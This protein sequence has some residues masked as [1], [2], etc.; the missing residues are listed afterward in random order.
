M[1]GWDVVAGVRVVSSALGAEGLKRGK[2]C[3]RQP[4]PFPST[5]RDDSWGCTLAR[6]EDILDVADAGASLEV[7]GPTM[8]GGAAAPFPAT[9]VALS[10]AVS[11]E[12]RIC[13]SLTEPPEE[14]VL[15][16]SESWPV[17]SLFDPPVELI[18]E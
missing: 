4:E 8:T 18:R 2:K 17:S 15:P 7:P 9:D 16:A 5:H 6:G 11:G 12:S 10:G 14:G 13:G 3:L 1:G